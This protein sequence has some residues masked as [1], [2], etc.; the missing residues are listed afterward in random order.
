MIR[1]EHTGQVSLYTLLV[2][3]RYGIGDSGL[4]LYIRFDLKCHLFI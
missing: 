2:R 4:L 3:P 1:T